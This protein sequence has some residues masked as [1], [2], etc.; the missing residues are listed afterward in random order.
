MP[1]GQ[2]VTCHSCSVSPT[3][4]SAASIVPH[5]ATV[6]S[7]VKLQTTSP[8]AA[9]SA[10]TFAT[11]GVKSNSPQAR[12]APRRWEPQTPWTT[13][14]VTE[15]ASSPS[16]RPLGGTTPSPC[17]SH[18]SRPSPSL[19]RGRLLAVHT[20]LPISTARSALRHRAAT[21]GRF[22]VPA[23]Q[24]APSLVQ[25]V[26]LRTCGRGSR[27]TWTPAGYRQDRPTISGA[28]VTV[29]TSG[30]R[31]QIGPR[32][33]AAMASG[34]QKNSDKEKATED[35]ETGE[36]ANETTTEDGELCSSQHRQRR[37]A[38]QNA[39]MVRRMDLP[40]VAF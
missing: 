13:V 27:A 26:W 14:G 31:E 32:A 12:D 18:G 15:P 5:P 3:L 39:M 8:I 10:C 25:H 6:V 7:I 37:R 21:S 29:T 11:P 19:A 30:T 34:R 17:S 38:L 4:P 35:E 2:V 9:A 36:E 20:A 40:E 24:Q 1:S 16:P 22:R 23:R 28:R 33:N